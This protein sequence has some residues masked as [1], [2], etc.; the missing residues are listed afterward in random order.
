M[1][2]IAGLA[3]SIG[4]GPSKAKATDFFGGDSAVA[5][6]SVGISGGATDAQ[7]AAKS[8]IASNKR[9]I[10]RIHGYKVQLT[11]SDN[12]ALRKLQEKVVVINDKAADGIA[13]EY[14]LEKRID[15]LAAADK[16]LGKPVVDVE[17]DDILATL[18]EKINDLLAKKLTPAVENRV[19]LLETLSASYEDKIARNVDSRLPQ[20]QLQNV[21]RQL[22]ALTP[23]RSISQLSDNERREYDQLVELVNK[24]VGEK[25]SLNSKDSIRVASL[26][27]TITELQSS[28]PADTSGQP[29]A[30]DVARAYTRF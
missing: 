4:S 19:K 24:H 23:S 20:L 15:Y 28:L 2:D 14:D 12:Q 13:T 26:Q 6:F 8:I 21:T 17:A 25:L 22:L 10:N 9:E 29:T 11:P 18:N 7:L 1:V 30:A 16:I 5:I 27:A 3:A